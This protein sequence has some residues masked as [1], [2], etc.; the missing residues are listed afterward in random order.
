MDII[1][2]KDQQIKHKTS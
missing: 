2:I 1:F